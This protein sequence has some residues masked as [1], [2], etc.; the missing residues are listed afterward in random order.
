MIDRRWFLGSTV[1]GVVV[2]VVLG[3]ALGGFETAW[4]FPGVAALW[5]LAFGAMGYVI[6]RAEPGHPVGRKLLYVGPLGILNQIAVELLSVDAAWAAYT[7]PLLGL[8]V[9]F[10]SAALHALAVFPDGEWIAPWARV[11]T[12]VMWALAGASFLIWTFVDTGALDGYHSPFYVF[13]SETLGDRLELVW[14]LSTV[15]IAAGVVY[16]FFKSTG[17]VRRQF[18]WLALATISTAVTAS[19]AAVFDAAVLE[20]M[21]A[22]GLALIPV[23]MAIAVT[24]YRLYE[25]D[26]IVSRTASYAVAIAAL[27]GLYG[28]TVIGSRSVLGVEGPLPVAL[29]TLVAAFALFPV[30]RR[31]QAWVDRRFFRSRY[32]SASVVGSFADE[33][34]TTVDSEA[35]VERTESV[36]AETFQ[37]ETVEIWLAEEPA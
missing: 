32:D 9:I 18:A 5:A 16:G 1:V 31:V 36:V 37:A 26:R 6:D 3:L 23:S 17:L 22:I 25:I 34:R 14:N 28:V 15:A 30:V 8:W 7:I 29:W 4:G 11:T 20:V 27:G 10:L 2:V 35:L 12:I 21:A 13:Q 24:R 19:A 33:M